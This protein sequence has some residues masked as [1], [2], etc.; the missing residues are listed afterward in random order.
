MWEK[1]KED[2]FKRYSIDKEELIEKHLKLFPEDE[3]LIKL[4]K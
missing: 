3:N 4:V 1:C 2:F